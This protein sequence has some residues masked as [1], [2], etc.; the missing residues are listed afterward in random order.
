MK[1]LLVLLS[2]LC[3]IMVEMPVYAMPNGTVTETA[4]V[5]EKRSEEVEWVYRTYQGKLQKRLWS[6]TEGVW[7]TDWIDC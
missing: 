3:V 2:L 4:T 5:Q 6:I 1:K 7:L